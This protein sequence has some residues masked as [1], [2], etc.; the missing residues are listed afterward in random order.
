MNI[1]VV[2]DS[3]PNIL[4]YKGIIRNLVG[5]AAYCHTSSSD[6]LA[7]CEHNDPD[8]VIVDYDMP[9]PN[10]LQF[11]TLFRQM[12]GKHDIPILM[13]TAETGKALRYKALESGA[14]DFLNKPVDIIEFSA[15]VRNML[16]LRRS[17]K[18]LVDRTGWL[19]ADV[20]KATEQ[21]VERERET[22]WR[23]AR[24]AEY[25]DTETG[26]HIVRMAHY[27]KVIAKAAGLSADDQEM[28]LLAAPMHDIGK[29]AI[30]D[31]ILLKPAKLDA[32]EFRTMKRHTIIGHDI[33]KGSTSQLLR[34]AA[35]IALSH[36]EKYDGSGY[37][38]GLEREDIPLFG[39]ICAL[40]DVFDALTSIRPYKVAYPVD[41]SVTII[42]RGAGQQFDPELVR[43]FKFALPEIL[44]L[45]DEYSDTV[46]QVRRG[47][48]AI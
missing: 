2:E 35:E 37:P 31:S 8:V 33:L 28:L 42:L 47:P 26:M 5:C 32:D 7:W 17:R 39:R 30:P 3:L 10:G 44:R 23:L 27:C 15:R 43:A 46:Q 11:I 38:Y 14:T 29:I 48:I 1:L 6:A 18:A 36:H 41:E 40:S 21:I 45:K 25:R 4:I 20:K 16:E 13:V 22:I 24:V 12:P 19:A 34:T 9:S